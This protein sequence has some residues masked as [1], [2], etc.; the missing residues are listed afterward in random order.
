MALVFVLWVMTIL[1]AV[2]IQMR[3]SSHLRMQATAYTGMSAK[4]RYLSRAG[5]EKAM[6][7]LISEDDTLDGTDEFWDGDEQEEYCNVELGDGTYTLY[8]GTDSTGNPIYGPIDEA[9]RINVNT[10]DRDVL[11]LLPGVGV[12]LARFIEKAR[13]RRPYGDLSDLMIVD[14]VTQTLLYGEDQNE[15]GLLDPNENDGDQS[16]PHD[17]E[18]GELNRGLASYL[19]VWSAEKNVSV[20]GVK[21]VNLTSASTEDITK[22]KGISEKEARSIV[23]HRKKTKIKTIVDLLDV[24]LVEVVEQKSDKGSQ[25][26]GQQPNQPSEKKQSSSKSQ[27]SEKKQSASALPPSNSSKNGKSNN[28]NSNGK[29][30]NSSKNNGKGGEPARPGND[31]SNQNERDSKGSKEEVKGTG[32]K[33]FTTAELK[34]FSDQVTFTDDEI[35]K[36]VINVNVASAEVLACLPGVSEA[37]A[38]EIVN[39]RENSTEKF[40]STVSL[41]DIQGMTTKI[42]EGIYNL[43]SVRSNVYSVRSFGVVGGG[44]VYA[45][46][47]AVIDT[48][49]DKARIVHWRELE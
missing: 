38:L 5:I 46:A 36:G 27:S 42:L 2:A 48:T 35:I 24:E 19:T 15:N 34:G 25:E 22:V 18:D 1:C 14:G 33:A 49:G 16:W 40:S 41:L 20:D 47:S 12:E 11:A 32:K 8:A 10:A 13:K 29:S 37:L 17:D 31:K 30:N 4:A 45:C 43:I 39:T 28:S 26:K 3:F 6:A 44:D 23:E 21:R 9:A 7:D